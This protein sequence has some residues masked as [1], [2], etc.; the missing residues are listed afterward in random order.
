VSYQSLFLNLNRKEMEKDFY[1]NPGHWVE[2]CACGPTHITRG[3]AIAL[4]RPCVREWLRRTAHGM[5]QCTTRPMMPLRWLTD[6]EEGTES[7]PTPQRIPMERWKASA[8]TGQGGQRQ[9]AKLTMQ[10]GV[11]VTMA[12]GKLWEV[13]TMDLHDREMVRSTLQQEKRKRRK[14]TC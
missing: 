8:H 12:D 1:S 3:A 5:A 13:S 11:A 4:P 6:D 14:L 9:G 2:S 7:L 10:N